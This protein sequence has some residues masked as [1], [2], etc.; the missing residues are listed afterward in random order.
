MRLP[1][2][3]TYSTMALLDLAIHSDEWPV[4]VRCIS[5]RQRISERYLQQ[6]FIRLHA[7]N[8][9]RSMPGAHGGFSLTKPLSEIRL[10]EIIRVT[11]GSISPV[12]CVDEPELCPLSDVCVMRDVW[13][14]MKKAIDGVLESVTLQDLVEQQRKIDQSGRKRAVRPY[15]KEED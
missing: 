9:V 2:K 14:R 8:L 3:A 6:L 15:C 7:A 1:T 12:V 13:G 5:Q 4:S 11:E 10:S